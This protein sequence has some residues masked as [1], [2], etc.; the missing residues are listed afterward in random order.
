L[1]VPIYFKVAKFISP[2]HQTGISLELEI[3][4]LGWFSGLY[5][6]VLAPLPK[7]EATE[8]DPLCTRLE[9]AGKPPQWKTPLLSTW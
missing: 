5:S 1:K 8:L 7:L 2:H 4:Q 9:T 3:Q 6:T